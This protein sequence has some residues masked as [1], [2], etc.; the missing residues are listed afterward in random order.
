MKRIAFY[1]LGCKTNQYETQ[2]LKEEFLRRGFAMAEGEEPADVYVINTCTVTNLAD[3]KSRQYI[4]RAKKENPHCVVAATGCY[5][6][7]NPEE[8]REI[9]GVDLLAGTEEKSRLPELVEGYL[10]QKEE[11]RASGP[12]CH[13]SP[14]AGPA[15]YRETGP[16]ASMESRTRAYVKIQE[17]CD[18]F[19]SYCV[20]PYARGGLRSRSLEAIVRE[21]ES[22]LEKGF[23]EI[24]LTGINAALY[25]RETGRGGG[26]GTGAGGI[27]AVVA[28]LDRLKGEFRIRIGSLEPTVVDGSYVERLL[29]Y[30]KL[31]R[32]MHLSVQSGSDAVLAAMNRHYTRQDFLKITELLRRFDPAYGIST[33]I[34]VGFPGE[35]EAD[36][37]ESLSLVEEVRFC[38]THIFPY[39][40]RKGTR[41]AEMEGQL[42]AG[43]KKE[44]AARLAAAAEK[45]AEGFFLGNTGRV[46]SVLAEEWDP[47]RGLYSGYDENYIRV[48][49]RA[50]AGAPD[51]RGRFV[52]V[53]LTGLWA[54][55]MEGEME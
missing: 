32:H 1:T 31:C 55:G 40:R 33:D 17:G 5:V 6:Q 43:V 15:E 9:E 51:L 54:D 7:M 8:V 50:G 4:R 44:R 12:V 28:A 2:A 29:Q 45:A 18:Q 48:C 14:W 21:T 47:D 53:R 25:G 52:P 22:L 37:R 35:S 10:K 39:S 30:E 20:I 34:I 11:D 24:V 49:F 26:N 19:C 3:R 42:G 16:V 36:F 46:A 38:K 13:V 27:E 23:R 41:A